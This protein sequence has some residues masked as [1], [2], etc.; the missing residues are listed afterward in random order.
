MPE[1]PPAAAAERPFGEGFRDLYERH[2]AFVWRVVSRLAAP[3][4]D[5]EDLTQEVFEIAG[6]KL[7]EFEGRAQETTWLFRIA[8][9]VVQADRRKRRR[10]DLL[11]LRWLRPE[12]PPSAAG[13]DRDLARSEAQAVVR[14]A[15][16]RM[17]EKKRVV[18]VLF[19]LEGMSGPEIAQI[20]GCPVDTVWT[21]LFHAR[22][23]FRK[24]VAP[25][26]ESGELDAAAPAGAGRSR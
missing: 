20:V 8:A 5:P 6:R 7:A 10:Q 17:S 4:A 3:D 16:A 14:A 19:E 11:R 23:E 18:F 22:R 21:R 2:F 15:L 25:Y 1:K 12:A 24:L 13:P 9:N 26:V